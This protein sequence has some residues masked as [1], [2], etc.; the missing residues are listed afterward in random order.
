M[1]EESILQ[2]IITYLRAELPGALAN[3]APLNYLDR[4]DD[5]SFTARTETP[6]LPAPQ[7]IWNHIHPRLNFPSVVVQ[8]QATEY[9]E[10]ADECGRLR[11]GVATYTI[12]L[13]VVDGESARVQ[14][15]WFRYA[16]AVQSLL[17][18]S[19]QDQRNVES[20][21]VWYEPRWM[22]TRAANGGI[23]GGDAGLF[24]ASGQIELS[25]SF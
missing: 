1:I 13:A 22:I 6:N 8:W 3:A 18:A 16:G 7:E 25:V 19:R 10:E 14:Y 20:G 17:L 15:L 5:G 12:D 23:A 11:S 9:T 2:S 4:N 21:G 24:S